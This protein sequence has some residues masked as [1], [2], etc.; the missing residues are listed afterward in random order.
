MAAYSPSGPASSPWDAIRSNRALTARREESMNRPASMPAG[1][2][3]RPSYS[4][5]RRS[6]RRATCGSRDV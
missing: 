2:A 1:V 3:G 4:A 5:A 6:R